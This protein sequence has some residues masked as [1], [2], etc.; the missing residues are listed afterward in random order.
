MP[1]FSLIVALPFS[2]GKVAVGK[3]WQ[4]LLQRVDIIAII[5]FGN[6]VATGLFTRKDS[7]IG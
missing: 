2:D 4:C 1:R 5:S 6:L 7:E 3:N